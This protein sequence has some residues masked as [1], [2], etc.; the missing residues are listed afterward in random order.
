[1]LGH[2]LR[3]MQGRAKLDD[4]HHALAASRRFHGFLTNYC[5]DGSKYVV[6]IDC[7]PLR[8]AHG[9]VVHFIAFEREDVRRRGRPMRGA[10]GRFEPLTTSNESLAPALQALGVLRESLLDAEPMVGRP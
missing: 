5:R 4:L 10:G 8:S 9:D 7:R 6:E 2:K 3:S 1:V